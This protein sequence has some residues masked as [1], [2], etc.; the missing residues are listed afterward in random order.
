[1]NDKVTREGKLEFFNALC[2]ESSLSFLEKRNQRGKGHAWADMVLAI[3]AL[4]SEAGEAESRPK[5]SRG[6]VVNSA[7]AMGV[8]PDALAMCLEE[9]G[10]R[11]KEG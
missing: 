11:V 6:F 7:R 5:V 8:E 2:E 10:V 9:A 3:R 4:I 1:M